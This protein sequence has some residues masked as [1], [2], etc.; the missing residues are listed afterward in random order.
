VLGTE[1]GGLAVLRDRKFSTLT[2]QDGLTDEYVLALSQIARARCGRGRE[3][4]LNEFRDGKFHALTTGAGVEQQ[5]CAEQWA[6]AP[7]GECVG[8]NAG[9]V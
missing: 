3:G 8:W 7:N 5:R 9:R 1:S 2:A 6:A 4:G